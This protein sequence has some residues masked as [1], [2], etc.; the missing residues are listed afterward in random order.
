MMLYPRTEAERQD[1]LRMLVVINE[2]RGRMNGF[3][4]PIMT[5]TPWVKTRWPKERYL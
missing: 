3:Y 4:P 1:A 2:L 5:D